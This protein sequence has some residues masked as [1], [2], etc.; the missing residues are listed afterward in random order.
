MSVLLFVRRFLSNSISHF[1]N[2]RIYSSERARNYPALLSLP[3]FLLLFSSCTATQAHNALISNVLPSHTFAIT[4]PPTLILHN[5]SGSITLHA[6][7]GSAVVITATQRVTAHGPPL[8]TL[9]SGANDMQVNY[10]QQGNTISVEALNI[11]HAALSG[12]SVDFDAF[13][14]AEGSVQLYTEYGSIEVSGVHGSTM[15]V[16]QSGSISASNIDGVLTINDNSG[17]VSVNNL[18]GPL[19]LKLSN[20]DVELRRMTLTGSSRIST[21]RGSIL[22]TGSLSSQGT[23]RFSTETGAIELSL[24]INSS[25]NLEASTEHGE[26]ENE[27]GSTQVGDNPAP[28]LHVSTKVGSI[29]IRSS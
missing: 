24:P 9:T 3:I 19:S 12:L 21:E 27:F 5:D 28:L 23:Y 7:K 2:I 22:F 26:I 13:M 10:D 29:A 15:L 25:F 6:G 1:C 11:S 14:P 18:C 4:A 16:S 20:G 8:G 17:S